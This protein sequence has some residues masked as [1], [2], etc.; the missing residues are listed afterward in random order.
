MGARFDLDS[1]FPTTALCCDGVLSSFSRMLSDSSFPGSPIKLLGSIFLDPPILPESSFFLAFLFSLLFY[2]LEQKGT[3]FFKNI[4]FMGVG[5]LLCLCLCRGMYID[6][7]GQLTRISSS[8]LRH[9]FSL[10]FLP[11][12]V[13]QASKA[14]SCLCIPSHCKTART[15]DVHHLIWLCSRSPGLPSKCLYLPSHL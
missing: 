9:S 14:V 6:I 11:C 10:V 1:V 12:C 2:P 4:M 7:R 5:A 15:T 13:L 3:L 8:L